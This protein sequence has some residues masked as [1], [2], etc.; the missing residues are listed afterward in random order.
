MENF[1]K[2][3]NEYNLKNCAFYDW[4]LVGF[5]ILGNELYLG[6]VEYG[7]NKK[8]DLFVEFKL[9]NIEIKKLNLIFNKIK[10]NN[11]SGIYT[12]IQENKKTNFIISFSSDYQLE[13]ECEKISIND[14]KLLNK[15]VV[16]LFLSHSQYQL[17]NLVNIKK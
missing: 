7:H 1:E 9:T 4:D 12:N 2:L 13:I 15:D 3:E 16:T 11:I 14:V 5:N 17:K 10:L 8:N 6:I